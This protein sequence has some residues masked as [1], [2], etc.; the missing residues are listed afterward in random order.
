MEE[1]GEESEGKISVVYKLGEL[2]G[3]AGERKQSGGRHRSGT[4]KMQ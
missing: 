1:A 2:A 3:K 4:S